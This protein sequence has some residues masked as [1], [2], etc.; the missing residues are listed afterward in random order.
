MGQDPWCDL[1]G[2][3]SGVGRD[4]SDGAGVPR[5]EVGRGKG[6]QAARRASAEP[7]SAGNC[8]EVII[9]VVGGSYAF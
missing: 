5:G 2:D 8:R 9:P 7:Y 6:C 3:D 4:M 1:L